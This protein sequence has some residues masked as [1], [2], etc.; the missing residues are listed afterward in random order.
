MV[1]GKQMVVMIQVQRNKSV[2]TATDCSAGQIGHGC[3]SLITILLSQML[4]RAK[5]RSGAT[6]VRRVTGARTS[7]SRSSE[8]L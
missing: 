5:V 4:A 1:Q 3:N 8:T 6:S 7:R 2:M